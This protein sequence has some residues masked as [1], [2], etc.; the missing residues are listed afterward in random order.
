MDFIITT[1]VQPRFFLMGIGFKHGLTTKKGLDSLSLFSNQSKKKKFLDLLASYRAKNVVGQFHGIDLSHADLSN[2]D[3]T[4]ID[5]T[6][7]NLT[8]ANLSGAKLIGTNLTNAK[9]IRTIL[10]NANLTDVILTGV[11]TDRITQLSLQQASNQQWLEA[12]Q[13]AIENFDQKWEKAKSI[14]GFNAFETVL[15]QLLKNKVTTVEIVEVIDTALNSPE[16]GRLVFQA[17][18]GVDVNCYAHLLTTFNTIQVLARFG[19]LLTN[20][21]T[22]QLLDLAVGLVKQNALDEA[23]LPL[24][25]HQWSEGRR[26]PNSD[27]TGPNVFDALKVQLA[28]RYQFTSQLNLPLPAKHPMDAIDVAGLMLSDKEFVLELINNS[29]N[30]QDEI[31]EALIAL[32]IWQLYLERVLNIQINWT[33]LDEAEQ[34]TLEEFLRQETKKI[35]G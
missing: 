23:T 27:G 10:C 31:V 21:Q 3:L 16:I 32:P 4:G 33:D 22:Q 17:V 1:P 19:K 2:I 29:I 20:N 35:I 5:L 7:A 12:A 11:V 13:K 6:G 24:M 28:L 14:D 18:Q 15:K 25:R 8:S 34:I 26:A 30:D 9:L